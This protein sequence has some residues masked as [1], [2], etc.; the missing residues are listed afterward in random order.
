MGEVGKIN[1]EVVGKVGGC[2]VR[3]IMVNEG[4]E[5]RESDRR[6]NKVNLGKESW[7]SKRK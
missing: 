2:E 7:R 6:V 1:G 3:K 4:R 5:R